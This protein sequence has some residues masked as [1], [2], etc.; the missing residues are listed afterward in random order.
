MKSLWKCIA[1][2]AVLVLA[3]SACGP[4]PVP[5]EEA[6]VEQPPATQEVVV[7]PTEIPVPIEPATAPPSNR[8]LLVAVP[9]SSLPV[10]DGDSSDEQWK[11]APYVMIGGMQWKAVYTDTDIAFLLRYIDRDLSIAPGGTYYWDP[12]TSSWAQNISTGRDSF[13]ISFDISSQMLT[14]S[15]D[16]FC[17]EDPPGSGIFHHQTDALGE[18]VDI[19]AANSRSSYSIKGREGMGGVQTEDEYGLAKGYED[20][21]WLMGTITAKQN[22][23]L[24]F[25]TTNANNPRNIVAGDVTFVDYAEDKVITAPG[26][27]LCT[28]RDRPLDLYCKNC[29]D[30]IDL[31]F[32]PL[33]VDM[34]CPD[35]GEIKTVGNY[36]IPYTAPKYMETKPTDF[37]DAMIMTQ[38]EIDSGEAVAVAGLTPQQINEYWANYDAVNG[39]IPFDVLKTPS[40]SMADVM[41]AENWK[42][43]TWTIEVTRKLVTPY[44]QQ[45]VQFDDLTKDYSFSVT[46]DANELMFGADYHAHGG[47]IMKFQP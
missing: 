31:P 36:D 21:V 38:A 25:E 32:D 22:S 30:L 10:I 6:T 29:H 39:V 3:V 12:A 4:A 1:L 35:D 5:T 46:I 43:G 44:G 11:S 2:L 40:G 7:P 20:L 23:P 47:A 33:E 24:V 26:D 45:D 8:Y 13:R 17:K 14:E 41:M 28:P 18:Y 42:N 16:T 9:V 37:V 19:W 15:C 34:T 27:P